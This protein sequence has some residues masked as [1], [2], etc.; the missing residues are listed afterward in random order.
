MRDGKNIR[1]LKG[2]GLISA[3]AKVLKSP[4]PL[5]AYKVKVEGDTISI[6]V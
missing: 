5:R 6:E 4:T 2:K 1:W 3:M